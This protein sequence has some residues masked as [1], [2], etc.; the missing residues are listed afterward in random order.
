LTIEQQ[1]YP[2]PGGSIFQPKSFAGDGV[3]LVSAVGFREV[4]L[5]VTAT[6]TA[7]KIVAGVAAGG[8]VKPA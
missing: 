5:M 2:K 3:E 8:S 7:D 1:R 6:K 4:L